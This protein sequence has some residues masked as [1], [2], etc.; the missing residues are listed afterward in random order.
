MNIFTTD[1]SLAS[2]PSWFDAKAHPRLSLICS[3]FVLA[4]LL[5]P[6]ALVRLYCYAVSDIGAEPTPFPDP[7][8]ALIAG[9]GLAFG[10]SIVGASFL[11][12]VFRFVAR[13]SGAFFRALLSRAS[14]FSKSSRPG[15]S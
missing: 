13:I 14:T 5:T 1:H 11:L 2:Q 10:F 6:L 15:P 3:A 7:W 8:L 4:L 9:L 12:F